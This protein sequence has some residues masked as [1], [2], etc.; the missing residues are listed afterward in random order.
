MSTSTNNP[1]RCQTPL[2][3]T[4][5]EFPAL[6]RAA[7]KCTLQI[8]ESYREAVSNLMQVSPLA[9]HVDMQEHYLAFV[10]LDSFAGTVHTNRLLLCEQHFYEI[11]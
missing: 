3:G 4:Q 10:D 5:T 7:L 6:R 9:G 11:S 2:I 8:I 1:P